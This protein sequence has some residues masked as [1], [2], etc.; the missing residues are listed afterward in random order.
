MF[1]LSNVREGFM[2]LWT[3]LELLFISISPFS[4]NVV[5]RDFHVWQKFKIWVLVA[6][7]TPFSDECI[8]RRTRCR[9]SDSSREREP[10][11]DNWLRFYLYCWCL[12]PHL[13]M[14]R[15]SRH[16][17]KNRWICYVPSL[18]SWNTLHNVS[19]S[20]ETLTTKYF[21]RTGQHFAPPPLF[22][23]IW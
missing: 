7:D 8:G 6:S 1:W 23:Y 9:G 11:V 5:L 22:P 13:P 18:C 10:C 15:L 3:G 17:V 12:C 2:G 21:Y 16:R 19:R 14:A 4:W 20:N